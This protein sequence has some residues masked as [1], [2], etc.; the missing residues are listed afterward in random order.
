[1]EQNARFQ[2]LE[3][4][5]Q[6]LPPRPS[7]ESAPVYRRTASSSLPSLSLNPLRSATTTV[8]S[9]ASVL[10]AGVHTP[11]LMLACTSHVRARILRVRVLPRLRDGAYH[12]NPH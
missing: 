3:R 9:T 4:T 12:G 8:H 11:M 5:R 10:D 7:K 2:H 1:M 6:Y